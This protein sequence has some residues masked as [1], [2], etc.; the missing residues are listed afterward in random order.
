MMYFFIKLQSEIQKILF[1]Y[2]N[3]SNKQNNL[4]TLTVCLKNNMYK[5]NV[6]VIK[7]NTETL[8]IRTNSNCLSF[9]VQR[10]FMY[11]SSKWLNNISVMSNVYSVHSK[12][13]SDM[14]CFQCQE[15]RHYVN[16]CMKLNTNFNNIRVFTAASSKKKKCLIK[17]ST[18]TEQWAKVETISSIIVEE[19]IL[20]KLKQILS[21]I[22]LNIS[23]KFNIINQHFTIK[24]DMTKINAELSHFILLNRQF[25]YYYNTYLV[26]YCLKNN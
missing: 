13:N 16:D 3:L 23:V 22:L 21:R 1:N 25:K 5:F 11:T 15:K 7:R 6:I 4:I 12:N 9:T 2:Q 14:I 19:T 8:F 20:T 17:V 18:S 10:A 26:I 24:K